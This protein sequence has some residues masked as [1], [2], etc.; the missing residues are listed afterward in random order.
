MVVALAGELLFNPAVNPIIPVHMVVKARYRRSALDREVIMSLS[1]K[2]PISECSVADA[3]ANLICKL[4][5]IPHLNPELV[6]EEAV[7]AAVG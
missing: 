3:C 6:V 5:Y 1:I 2:Y 4:N 7:L